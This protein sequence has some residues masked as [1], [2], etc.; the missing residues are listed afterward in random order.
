MYG[1]QGLSSEY[2]DFDEPPKLYSAIRQLGMR[3]SNSRAITDVVQKTREERHCNGK[4]GQHASDP[5][6][7]TC[8]SL[9][10]ILALQCTGDSLSFFL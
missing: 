4:K 10:C 5:N 7:G 9:A 3:V 8:H 1:R 2:M 6:S